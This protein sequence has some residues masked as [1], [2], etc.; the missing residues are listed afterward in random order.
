MYR[1][2]DE[3]IPADADRRQQRRA[4]RAELAASRDQHAPAGDV[5]DHLAEECALGCAAGQ[6]DLVDGRGDHVV[7]VTDGEGQPFIHGA[8]QVAA[9]VLVGQPEEVRAGGRFGHGRDNAVGAQ[10]RQVDRAVRPDGTGANQRLDSLEQRGGGIRSGLFWPAELLD[11][12]VQAGRAGD[13][14]RRAQPVATG[15]QERHAH[16][17]RLEHGPIDH[18]AVQEVRAQQ[19]TRH[20]GIDR[21]DAQRGGG[22][23]TRAQHDRRPGGQPGQRGGSGLHGPDHLLRRPDRREQAAVCVQAEQRDH[24]VAV[25]ARADV[26]G[27]TGRFG[28]IDLDRAGEVIGQPVLAADERRGAVQH[29]RLVFGQPAQYGQRAALLHDARG[30]VEDVRHEARL[31]RTEAVDQRLRAAIRPQ[32]RVAHGAALCVEQPRADHVARQTDGGDLRRVNAAFRQHRVDRAGGHDPRFVHAG[33]GP[34]GMRCFNRGAP[35]NRPH[36]A[37]VGGE[38]RRLNDRCARIDAEQIVLTGS[39]ARYP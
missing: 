38:Q 1:V 3:R 17:A 12:P 33:F 18:E 5:R 7:A 39:H 20:T 4:L 25:A 15:Q 23:V 27:H 29:V 8:Q 30:V 35:R 6:P 14:D 2:R 31:V 13:V 19:R 34:G 24:R 9:C 36:F 26:A 21:A 32:D 28:R 22:H 16:V 10:V 37:P 11:S